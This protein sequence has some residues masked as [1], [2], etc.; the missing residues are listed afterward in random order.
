MK[1]SC[2]GTGSQHQ[3]QQPGLGRESWVQH[4]ARQAAVE[5]RSSL[6]VFGSATLQ[7]TAVWT[8]WVPKQGQWETAS[9]PVPALRVPGRG[10]PPG[11]HTAQAHK[12]KAG[13]PSC[14]HKARTWKQMTGS[15][16]KELNGPTASSGLTRLAP[17][18]RFSSHSQCICSAVLNFYRM[19]YTSWPRKP[20]GQQHLC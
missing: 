1:A 2:L 9:R 15:F 11:S 8:R 14:P 19:D 10:A 20:G 6:S 7:T 4:W 13:S 17:E 5:Q 3:A 12:H 16:Q 18:P